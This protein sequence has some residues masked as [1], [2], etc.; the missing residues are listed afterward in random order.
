MTSKYLLWD[1][2]HTLAYRDGM[3]TQTIYDLL[4]KLDCRDLS[5]DDISPYMKSGFPW[6]TPEVP[7]AQFF[8]AT[9]WW[10]HMAG[11]FYKVLLEMGVEPALAEV[12]A[13]GVREEYTDITKWR[14]FDDTMHAL[15]KAVEAGYQNIIVSNHVP[16]LPALVEGLGI[17]PYI[18]SIYN[19]AEV[20]YEKPNIMM[21]RRVLDDLGSPEG[22]VM[23]GDNY[24]ADVQGALA[25]G[26]DAILVRKDNRNGYAKYAEDLEGVFAFL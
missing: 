7:H 17:L 26:I 9:P 20:G 4:N 25:A 21:F 5:P 1:F 14:L 12:V 19:S 3:W 13:N 6:H 11:H 23:I 10:E 22:M 8:R 16:E 2:D 18:T 24:T 15:K